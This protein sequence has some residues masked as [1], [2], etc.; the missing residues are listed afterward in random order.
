MT[1]EITPY[2]SNIERY[3]TRL[4]Y[5]MLCLTQEERVELLKRHGID[6]KFNLEKDNREEQTA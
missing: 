3:E 5:Q 1:T 6:L 4:Y 2:S